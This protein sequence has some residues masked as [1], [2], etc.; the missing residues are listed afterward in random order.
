MEDKL[1]KKR[2]KIDYKNLIKDEGLWSTYKR[3]SKRLYHIKSEK[4][5]MY[6]FCKCFLN[7]RLEQIKNYLSCL[8]DSIKLA[9][10]H[11]CW[12]D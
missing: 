3:Y 11:S 8:D 1:T 7:D 10:D 6:A 5:R 12:E 2:L 4:R 9:Q